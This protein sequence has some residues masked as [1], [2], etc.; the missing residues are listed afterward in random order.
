MNVSLL[1]LR[2]PQMVGSSW[3]KTHCREIEIRRMENRQ[4]YRGSYLLVISSMVIIA[5]DRL[6]VL[7]RKVDDSS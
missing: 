4:R 3:D 1:N 6:V 2:I 7:T 5:N